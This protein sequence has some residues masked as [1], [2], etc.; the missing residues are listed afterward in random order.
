MA[1][2]TRLETLKVPK[3]IFEARYDEGYRYLDRCGETLVHIKKYSSSWVPGTIN[4]QQGVVVNNKKTLVLTFGN[5]SMNISTS[6]ELDA[7]SMEKRIPELA[8]EAETI[9][10]IIVD[11]LRVPHTTRVGCRCFFVASCDSLEEA[12]RFVCNALKSPFLD[13][14]LEITKYTVSNATVNYVL[15]EPESGLRKRVIVSAVAQVEDESPP[16]T[17]LSNDVATGSVMVDVDTFSRPDHG[18]FREAS[19]FIQQ[20]YLAARGIASKTLE[21]ILNHQK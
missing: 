1:L 6:A 19:M 16:L 7:L 17:G 13:Q 12:Q 4:P 2:R 11:N 10:K 3:V 21:W 14:L 8:T 9:Y 5:Q 15:E 20:S 18:H